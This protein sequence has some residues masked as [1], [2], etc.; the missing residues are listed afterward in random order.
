[1]LYKGTLDEMLNRGDVYACTVHNGTM[2]RKAE[3]LKIA[4]HLQ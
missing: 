4:S 1:M 2:G 3:R